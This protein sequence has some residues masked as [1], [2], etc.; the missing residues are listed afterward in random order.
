VPQT[1]TDCHLRDHDVNT[2]IAKLDE[3]PVVAP[4][5]LSLI[6][7]LSPASGN[8]LECHSTP[9]RRVARAVDPGRGPLPIA[10]GRFLGA[11]TQGNHPIGKER[12]TSGLRFDLRRGSGP[13]RATGP[14]S[15]RE[16]LVGDADVACSSCHV[17]HGSFADL[18]GSG[19]ERT[20][21]LSCHDPE[22]YAFRGHFTPTC[23]DCH[24]LHGARG[25]S[26]LAER[27]PDVQCSAC[28]DGSGASAMIRVEPGLRGPS[29]HDDF[30]AG[31]CT[32][33]HKI[34]GSPVGGR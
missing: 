20:A 32:D 14:V 9:E 8:C 2:G 18:A 29:G 7:G 3:T 13:G 17:P 21:C 27:D 31:R 11:G 19:D 34:H 12:S 4:L 23:S 33:C 10:R 16:R 28:H 6:P 15:A 24:S 25:P 5:F 30:Q 26:L 22:F 1:C